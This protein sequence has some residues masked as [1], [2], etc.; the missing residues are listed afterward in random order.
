MQTL[1]IESEDA[2]HRG[3]LPVIELLQVGVVEEGSRMD[4]DAIIIE[5]RRVLEKAQAAARALAP[6]TR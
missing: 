2:S 1:G 5:A 4:I 6:I 3:S